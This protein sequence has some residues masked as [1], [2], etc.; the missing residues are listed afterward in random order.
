M[1]GSIIEA[2]DLLRTWRENSERKSREI[3][4]LWELSLRDKMEMLGNESKNFS[5]PFTTFV[6]IDNVIDDNVINSSSLPVDRVSH[7]RTSLC[8]CIRLVQITIG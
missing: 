7:S 4:D 1:V 3:V 2:R 5:S 8:C 6:Y